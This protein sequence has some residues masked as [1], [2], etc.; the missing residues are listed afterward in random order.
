MPVFRGREARRR[1][2]YVERHVV[3]R[4]RRISCR[5]RASRRASMPR[6]IA[7]DLKLA[8]RDSLSESMYALPAR[9]D[10]TA[11]LARANPLRQP[12]PRPA[13]ADACDAACPLRAH[14]AENLRSSPAPSVAAKPSA[15]PVRGGVPR[16]STNP[17]RSASYGMPRSSRL[18]VTPLFKLGTIM[19][20]DVTESRAVCAEARARAAPS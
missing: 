8:G 9:V 7:E 20:L 16:R 4:L 1:E 11:T 17:L 15:Q 19:G 3:E 5:R 12:P 2:H 10:S 14:A 13:E 6:L 18:T